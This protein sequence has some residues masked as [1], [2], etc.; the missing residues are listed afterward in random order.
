MFI[1]IKPITWE[2][3]DQVDEQARE[4]H[5]MLE[6]RLHARCEEDMPV[7][8]VT[9]VAISPSKSCVMSFPRRIPMTVTPICLCKVMNT[10]E[11][12]PFKT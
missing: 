11:T 3:Q 12:H 10:G 8:T 9:A 1:L 5:E 6:S 4:A 2:R 7:F